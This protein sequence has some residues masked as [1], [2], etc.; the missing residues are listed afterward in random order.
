M[1]LNKP[2]RSVSLVL[3]KWLISIFLP[4]IHELLLERNFGE[5]NVQ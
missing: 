1:V 2:L 5:Y 4:A 3:Y